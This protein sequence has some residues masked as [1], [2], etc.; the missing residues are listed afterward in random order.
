MRSGS[1]GIDP[2]SVPA[3]FG[4][5][6][7]NRT[8]RRGVAPFSSIKFPRVVGGFG[9]TLGTDFLSS[10][11]CQFGLKWLLL[12]HTLE[13]NRIRLFGRPEKSWCSC[14]ERNQQK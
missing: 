14:N 1:F 8:A 4:G 9:A 2:R 12:I 3:K 6:M 11:L 7:T 10:L 5:P 13:T